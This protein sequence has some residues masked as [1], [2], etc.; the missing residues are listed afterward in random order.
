[1]DAASQTL[2]RP[3]E[4]IPLRIGKVDFAPVIGI[5]LVFFIAQ[6]A[7]IGLHLLYRRL[8]Y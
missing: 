8:S 2:L 6:F 5:A 4:K 7:G 1:V 3:L